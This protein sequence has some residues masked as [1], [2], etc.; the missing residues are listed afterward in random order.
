MTDVCQ[1]EGDEVALL[2]IA[3]PGHPLQEWLFDSLSHAKKT[4]SDLTSKF[5]QLYCHHRATQCRMSQNK[6]SSTA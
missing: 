4:P 2:D 5:E 3:A 6:K 1:A